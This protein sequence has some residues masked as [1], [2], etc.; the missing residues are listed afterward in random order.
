LSLFWIVF[1]VVILVSVR[2]RRDPPPRANQGRREPHPTAAI[3]ALSAAYLV[4]AAWTFVAWY[5]KHHP[6]AKYKWGGDGW[7]ESW[8]YAGGADKFGHA[9]AT[10]ALARLGTTILHDWGGFAKRNSS[11]VSAGLSELLFTGVEVKDGFYYEFSFSDLTGDTTGMLLA[12]LFDNSARANE[13]FGFR[14]EYAPSEMYQR[15]VAGTSPCPS[16]GCSRWNVAED[17]SGQTYLA[18]LHLAGIKTV[19]KH[20]GVA[21]RFVDVAVGFDSRNYKPNPDPDIVEKPHQDVFL[22]LA[23]NAQGWCDWLLE[24][25]DSPAAER[26]RYVLHGLFEVFNLPYGSV[27]LLSTGREKSGPA[28]LKSS[29]RGPHHTRALKALAAAGASAVP[30]GSRARDIAP[31]RTRPRSSRGAGRG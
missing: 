22:G 5:R 14:V 26:A 15:K 4:F 2:A 11:L 20:L 16:G 17:Y 7:L 24:G 8:T 25:R 31:T 23:F 12:L 29:E 1:L 30:K 3:T 6:L 21:S 9:W 10:M 27:R 13:L 18:A 19:R 28:P